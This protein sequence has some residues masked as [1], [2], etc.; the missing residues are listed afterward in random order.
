MVI[1]EIIELQNSNTMVDYNTLVTCSFK[2]FTSVRFF[3]KIR[4]FKTF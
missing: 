1:N 3:R 2:H 4:N